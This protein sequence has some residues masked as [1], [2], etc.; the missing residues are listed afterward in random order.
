MA[1]SRQSSSVEE[2]DGSG[3]TET[4]FYLSDHSLRRSPLWCQMS[5]A[6]HDLVV[7]NVT[8]VNT[9]LFETRIKID[10][11]LGTGDRRCPAFPPRIVFPGRL[12]ETNF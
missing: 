5:V 8:A 9:L 6:V 11:P 3:V 7:M 2:H 4:Q 1:D 10:S 12:E